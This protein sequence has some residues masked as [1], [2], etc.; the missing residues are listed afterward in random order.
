[1]HSLECRLNNV[2]WII[3]QKHKKKTTP[4]T[5]TKF[6]K[7]NKI[8]RTILRLPFPM[9]KMGLNANRPKIKSE[10]HYCEDCS[11]ICYYSVSV[12][13]NLFCFIIILCVYVCSCCWCK[14]Q[15]CDTDMLCCSSTCHLH[16]GQCGISLA[17]VHLYVCCPS[18]TLTISFARSV[19][20]SNYQIK[21]YKPQFEVIACELDQFSCK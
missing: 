3:E 4:I 18:L 8:V 7:S 6:S 11:I 16:G 12:N 13:F 10:K 9:L 21:F 5:T 1:M 17:R 15:N 2:Y 20:T 19:P 14:K